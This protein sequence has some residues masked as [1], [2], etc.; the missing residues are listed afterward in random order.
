[1]TQKLCFYEAF[2]GDFQRKKPCFSCHFIAIRMH[3]F[4]TIAVDY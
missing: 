4:Y 3:I 1:M 2:D